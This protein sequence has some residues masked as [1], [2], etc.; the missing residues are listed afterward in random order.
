MV[1]KMEQAVEEKSHFFSPRLPDGFLCS[2]KT[3][4][5]K[6]GGGQLVKH[7]DVL[8]SWHRGE[9]TGPLAVEVTATGGCN[10]NCIHCSYQ[11]FNAYEGHKSFLNP[12]IFKNF[13]KDFQEL[14]GAEVFFAGRGEPLLNAHLADYV[15]YGH[16]LG[17][18]MAMS[19]NGVSLN[20]NRIANILPYM[21]W[22]RFSVNGGDPD[23]YARIHKCQPE[24]F[25]RLKANLKAVC[26]FRNTHGLDVRL[27]MQFVL[28]DGNHD[29]IPGMLQLH[30]QVGTDSLSFRNVAWT[31]EVDVRPRTDA[32]ELLRNVEKTDGVVV[33]WETFSDEEKPIGWSRC[34]GVNF[35]C[36]LYETG[37][38]FTCGRHC[39]V[40]SQI[41]NIKE[42]RFRD[43]WVSKSA[44]ALF[45]EVEQGREIPHCGTWCDVSK[46]NMVVEQFVAT[47]GTPAFPGKGGEL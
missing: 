40:P 8:R 13:L 11:Q 14:G 39:F 19:S 33:R 18:S 1:M 34:Y 25:E 28:M 46:D 3:K 6:S 23:S 12:T 10:H 41:G 22:I 38:V 31:E 37:E 27:N 5:V 30:Q 16:D 24:D 15:R 36:N 29:S 42:T 4:R 47:H 9:T 26:D 43:M 17:L 44:R 45:R 35:R 2:Q 20:E 21:K 32:V 7:L